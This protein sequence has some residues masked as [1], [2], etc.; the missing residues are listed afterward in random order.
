MRLSLKNEASECLEPK[1]SVQHL[2]FFHIYPRKSSKKQKKILTRKSLKI[3]NGE[4]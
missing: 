2:L 1:L 3:E 4:K